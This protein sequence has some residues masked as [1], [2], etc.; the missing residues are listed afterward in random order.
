MPLDSATATSKSFVFEELNREHQADP[1]SKPYNWH[2]ENSPFSP[3]DQSFLSGIEPFEEVVAVELVHT[4]GGYYDVRL[5]RTD[6]AALNY[7]AGVGHIK[8][9]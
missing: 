6:S 7:S 2:A 8:R 3:P 5:K 4:G 9:G 1:A